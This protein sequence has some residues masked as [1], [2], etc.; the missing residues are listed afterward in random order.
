MYRTK[1]RRA[2]LAVLSGNS[3]HP[4]AEQVYRQIRR[5]IPHISLATIYRNL[6][7]LAEEG[8]ILELSFPDEPNHYDPYTEL[9]YHF[10]CDLCGR[11]YDLESS[12]VQIA[13]RLDHQGFSV[14]GQ[15]AIFYG[16]CTGCRTK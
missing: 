8:L 12:Q 15:Q 16:A 1:Q 6:K 14:R 13:H 4:T 5:Q 2:I 3:S 7:R 9:H 10:R 11:I